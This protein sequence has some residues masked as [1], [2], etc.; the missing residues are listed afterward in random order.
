VVSLASAVEQFTVLRAEAIHKFVSWSK[1]ILY[2]SLYIFKLRK[3]NYIEIQ[4]TDEEQKNEK[5]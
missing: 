3:K 2:P 1:K 5:H 4:A